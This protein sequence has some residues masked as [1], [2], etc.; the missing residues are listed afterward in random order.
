MFF[1][2]QGNIL[3]I[4]FCKIFGLRIVIRPNSSPSGW[5]NNYLKN[6]IFSRILKL[7]DNIV[8]NSNDFKK[9][10]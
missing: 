9:R 5:S 7:S 3:C 8:V 4:L 10:T 2:F 6:V 1:C